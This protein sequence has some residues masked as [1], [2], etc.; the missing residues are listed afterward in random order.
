MTA[1]NPLT[2]PGAF[3]V[4]CN[5][6]ASHAGAAMWRDWQPD[7]VARDLDQLA[8]A[9]LHVLR[10]FPL[11]PD[12]QPLT[13]LGTGFGPVE[14]RHGE[15]ALADNEAGRAGV[16]AA[17]MERFRVFADL[18]DQRGLKLIV[19]LITGWM[20]GR[21]F[22]PPALEGRNA[23][24]DPTVILWQTRFVRHFVRQFRDHP[25][26]LAW[27]LGNECNCMGPATREQAW[28][29]TST[30][31]NAI[32]VEDNSRPVV[33]GMHSLTPA[34]N[35]AWRMQD[36][37]ELTD[38]LT[39]HPYPYFTPYCDQDPVNTIRTIL[40]ST[41]ESRFYADIGGQPCLVEEIGTLGPM[42]ASERI[43]GDFIRAALFSAWAHDCRGLLW[44]CAFDFGHLSQA[45]YDW[46][47]YE[48]ELGLLR[49]NGTPRPALTELGRFGQF[50]QQLP[51]RSLPPRHTD[52]VC[53]LS[54]G[55]DQ[56]A[57][58]YSAFV[59][60]KQAGLD[61]AFQYADQPLKDAPLYLLPGVSGGRILY[62][63]RWLELLERVKA[64]ATLYVSHEDGMLSPF[65]E[66]F[67]VDVLTRSRRTSPSTI[68]FSALPDRPVFTTRGPIRLRL[69][70]TRADVEVLAR[71]EDGNPVFTRA[72]YGRGALCFLS[73]PMER[74]LT[75]T[76]GIFHTAGAPACWQVYRHI[77]QAIPSS[78]I[79][80]KDHP[81]VGLT[82]HTL[83][84]GRR[85]LVLINYSPEP[86]TTRLTL[87]DG[88]QISEV[89]RGAWPALH[90]ESAQTTLPPND[91][92]VFVASSSVI[93]HSS[94]DKM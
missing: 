10:V 81:Q 31:T 8:G 89:W 45:P 85:A 54:E 13:Q 11:W 2:T 55:Q 9:G 6:W 88:W 73:V 52:A 3:L 57:I 62:R 64:G 16:S 70:P 26:V 36:Q 37:G 12:F 58:A 67:G 87:A 38:V 14:F 91:A 7:V 80:A 27:D 41:A 1:P 4:G 35:A 53:I 21:L 22:A 24:T 20:S 93:R 82:E 94:T 76:P 59:L 83:K 77:A 66:P 43:A 92:C 56:W 48:R 34:P 17:A 68:T 44:W 84:D 71:E 19:G 5:Y 51:M 33:S 86:V 40:H 63:R 28:V 29:W 78:R 72:P 18:A 47:A 32:R 42:V 65:T 74:E 69:Q 30:I 23:L 75:H 15:D 49:R 50:I 60:A 46:D 25:A 79:A 90:T 61:I 39:T